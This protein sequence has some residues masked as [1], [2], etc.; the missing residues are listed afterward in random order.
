M[1]QTIL[2]QPVFRFT[3]STRH[4]PSAD[5]G[6]PGSRSVRDGARAFG[7]LFGKVADKRNDVKIFLE[8]DILV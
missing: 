6:L 4:R 2:R 5:L 1:P 3:L 7:L 8:G